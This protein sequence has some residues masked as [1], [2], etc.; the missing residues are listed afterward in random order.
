MLSVAGSGKT[1][2][3]VE[4]L[5]IDRR[6]IIITYTDNNYD[7]MR[8]KIILKFGFLPENITIMSYFDFLYSF[9]YKPYLHSR[10]KAKG[11]NFDT[12]PQFTQRLRRTN[13]RYYV[14]SFGR[15]YHNRLAKLL[16]IQGL[17]PLISNRLKKF[18]DEMYIDEIQDFAG[19]DFNFLLAISN[20]DMKIRFVGDFFQHTFDTS[21]DGNV[22]RN[23][24]NNY[25]SYI[26]RFS[27]AGFTVDLLQLSKSYRCSK[28]ICDFVSEKLGIA[29][30]SYHD[31]VTD[32][33]L[34]QSNEEIYRIVEN[35]EIIKL[36][37]QNSRK[38]NCYSANWGETKGQDHYTDVCVVL[39]NKT[40]EQF[41]NDKLDEMNVKTRN[42][43]YVACTRA[44]RTLYFIP[45]RLL[46]SYKY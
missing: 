9:C 45:E 20:E 12:P 16:D 1:T 4:S 43:L 10:V 19:H 3:I 2:T 23:L 36:F 13:F 40:Y 17:N 5:S 33:S 41:I 32:V 29:I 31:T 6:A 35:S 25:E 7:N 15:L 46:S 26:Q 22:N 42:K 14:D 34:I 44:R 30:E 28:S 39:N 24:H 37:Y 21:R 8:N 11:Y 27:T 38:Y 18:F